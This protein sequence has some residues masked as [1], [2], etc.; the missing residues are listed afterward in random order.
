MDKSSNKWIIFPRPNPEA[1]LRLFCFH[2]AGGSAHVFHVGLDIYRRAWKGGGSTAGAR[3]QTR[4]TSYQ[5]TGAARP[6]R[7]ARVTAVNG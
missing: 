3:P 1:A 6:H 5:A 2:Y 4:R 7:G